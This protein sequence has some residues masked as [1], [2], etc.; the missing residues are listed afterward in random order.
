M[1]ILVSLPD[2]QEFKVEGKAGTS[3]MEAM[4]NQGVPVR[5]ECGGAMA[6]ATC[7]VHV[8]AGLGTRWST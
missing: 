2:G 4:R 1:H 3:V 5:S 6:C 8:S 7:H